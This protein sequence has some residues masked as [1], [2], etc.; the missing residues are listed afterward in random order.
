MSKS[1]TITWGRM[2][3]C[4]AEGSVYPKKDFP[5]PPSTSHAFSTQT[6][7]ISFLRE[8][9]FK[10]VGSSFQDH[11]VKHPSLLP[12]SPEARQDTL[13]GSQGHLHR[14][15]DLRCSSCRTLHLAM[16]NTPKGM[17]SG[18]AGVCQCLAPGN[19]CS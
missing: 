19:Q 18:C 8:L 14:H 9:L 3:Q 4:I 1:Y 6:M 5:K 15:R 11:P 7:T 2:K 10:S 13:A 16:P 12:S 17:L